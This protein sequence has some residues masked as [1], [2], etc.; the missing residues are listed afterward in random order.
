MRRNGFLKL[1]IIPNKSVM[2]YIYIRKSV[3]PEGI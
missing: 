2:N 1:K 3:Y